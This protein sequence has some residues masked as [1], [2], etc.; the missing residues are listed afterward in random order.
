MFLLSWN[1][2]SRGED[3]E[4]I[5]KSI[6]KKFPK[7]VRLIMKIK[8]SNRTQWQVERGYYVGINY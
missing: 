4:K 6:K 8:H 1:L 3:K 5:N 7:V 2:H